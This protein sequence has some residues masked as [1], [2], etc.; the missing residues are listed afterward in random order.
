MVASQ[1]A[2]LRSFS[3][4]QHLLTILCSLF[5]GH[6]P[7]KGSISLTNKVFTQPVNLIG[8]VTKLE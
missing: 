6:L 2:S 8:I 1:L 7:L 4:F 5:L 3:G